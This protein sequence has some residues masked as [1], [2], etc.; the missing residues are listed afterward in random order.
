[1]FE[2]RHEI[3]LDEKGRI[4]VPSKY[5]QMLRELCEGQ[6]TFTLDHSESCLRVY[7]RPVWE[8]MKRRLSDLPE[9]DTAA[10][11]VKWI[12]VGNADPVDMD[13]QGRVLIAQSL[14]Q[15]VNLAH[16]LVLTG[17]GS[18]L[19]LWSHDAYQ[20]KFAAVIAGNASSDSAALAEL[21]L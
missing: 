19:Q 11:R 15:Q 3:T 21:R 12:M 4:A 9:F 2:G 8:D 18:H 20:A 5:R 1:M 7:P 16:K 6:L 14:R 17:Q 10:Q 13:K